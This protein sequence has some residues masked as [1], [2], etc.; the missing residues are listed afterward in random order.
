MSCKHPRFRNHCSQSDSFSYVRYQERK[1]ESDAKFKARKARK[2]HED[3]EWAGFSENEDGSDADEEV[4]EHEQSSDDD[5]DDEEDGNQTLVKRL[6]GLNV[7]GDKGLSKRATLFFDQDIFADIDESEE[8]EEEEVEAGGLGEDSFAQ[9]D[10]E[11]EDEVEAKDVEMNDVADGD[12]ESED[13]F[14]IVKKTKEE[15]WNAEDEPMKNGR[16]GTH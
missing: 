2:D 5:S 10:S 7:I 4:I 14:E 6:D 9:F 16:P 12:E 13:E 1:A 15:R 11:G 3:G 8:E